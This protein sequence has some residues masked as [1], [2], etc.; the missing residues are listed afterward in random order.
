[1]PCFVLMLNTIIST[2][3]DDNCSK[4]QVMKKEDKTPQELIKDI[5]TCGITLKDIAS[6]INVTYSYVWL[7][8][9]GKR[10]GLAWDKMEKLRKIHSSVM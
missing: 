9:K 5:E 4:V 6:K 2:I 3:V 8:S 7:L 10:K 1:M